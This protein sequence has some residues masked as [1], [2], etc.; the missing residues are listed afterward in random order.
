MNLKK[1]FCWRD[2]NDIFVLILCME[3]SYRIKMLYRVFTAY[4]EFLRIPQEYCAEHH[5]LFAPTANGFE[6]WNGRGRNCL[7]YHAFSFWESHVR[8]GK[9]FIQFTFVLLC[10]LMGFLKCNR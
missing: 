8:T 3:K 2:G 7:S 4:S 5:C 6:C 10:I 9:W 1:Y